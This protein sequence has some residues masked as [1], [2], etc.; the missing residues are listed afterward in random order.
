[1]RIAKVMEFESK[2]KKF[3]IFFEFTAMQYFSL[4]NVSSKTAKDPPSRWRLV[5]ATV[6]FLSFSLLLINQIYLVKTISKE[7]IV[8]AKNIF[9][10]I[11]SESKGLGMCFTVIISVFKSYK[12]TV[13]LKLFHLNSRNIVE[14]L[15]DNPISTKRWLRN[16]WIRFTV[17]LCIY[18]LRMSV[19][20]LLYVRSENVGA[21]ILNIIFPVILYLSIVFKFTFYVDMINWQLDLLHK[22][23]LDFFKP[24]KMF[25]SSA[26]NIQ[27][28]MLHHAV[29]ARKIYNLIYM[30]AKIINNSNGLSV[31]FV[32]IFMIISIIATVYELIAV[33]FGPSR[34]PTEESLVG[35]VFAASTIILVVYCCHNTQ[36]NVS[37]HIFL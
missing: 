12:S 27:R 6:A 30:N 19:F 32:F 25:A 2:I 10:M 21:V 24:K 31:L 36:L 5:L 9:M 8:N 20:I 18:F 28:N 11:V 4:K 3:Q 23:L 14:M 17:F 22:M 16:A 34:H 1:V 26:K 13:D 35:L 7:D 29:T 37:L 15:H 33:S